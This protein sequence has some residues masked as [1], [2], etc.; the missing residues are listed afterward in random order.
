M[1]EH[2]PSPADATASQNE[3]YGTIVQG[4]V[5]AVTDEPT[6]STGEV[7]YPIPLPPP[8]VAEQKIRDTYRFTPDARGG[9]VDSYL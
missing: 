5:L 8:S 6:D 2:F 4:E 9:A 7:L 1:F 3:A